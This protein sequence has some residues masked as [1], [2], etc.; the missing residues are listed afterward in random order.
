MTRLT[1]AMERFFWQEYEQADDITRQ[2]KDGGHISEIE[3]S[4][5]RTRE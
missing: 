1:T 3:T 5:K 2:V 4:Q